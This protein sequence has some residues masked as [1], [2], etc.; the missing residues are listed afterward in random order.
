MR[1]NARLDHASEKHLV[2]LKQATGMSTT[3]IVRRSLQRYAEEFNEDDAARKNHR[4]LEALTGIADGSDDGSVF[5][6]DYVMDYLNE[7]HPDR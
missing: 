6:K 7:K 5:C 3:D 1:I 4:L 2:R